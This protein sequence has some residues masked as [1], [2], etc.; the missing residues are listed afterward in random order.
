[1]NYLEMF[2]VKRQEEVV[3]VV[4]TLPTYKV[5]KTTVEQVEKSR[6]QAREY[7]KAMQYIE[8]VVECNGRIKEVKSIT[9]SKLVNWTVTF[10]DDEK[11]I[12]VVDTITGYKYGTFSLGN[13]KLCKNDRIQYILF[14]LLQIVTCPNATEGCLK[15]CYAN[16]S[17][18]N[19]NA[20]N[21][22]SRNSRIKNTVL[23][24]YENFSEIVTEIINLVYNSTGKKVFF[25]WHE[26]GDIYSK[27][28][29]EKIKEVMETNTQVDFMFYTKTV[30]TLEEINKINK[31]P[32][33]SMR[34]SLDDTSSVRVAKK[35]HSENILNTIVV[36]ANQLCEVVENFD[37]SMVCNFKH[38]QQQRDEIAQQIRQ[39]EEEL[40][41]EHR[42][43]Y[44]KKIQTEINGLQKSLINK[45]QKCHS[46][47]K[48]HNKQRNTIM[49]GTH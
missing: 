45:N 1:M 13:K 22:T 38:T 46:C 17:N 16:K 33:V 2:G 25:R 49:F 15:F 32:N 26:S 35:V 34:Y 5:E 21:S 40:E 24:M 8:S 39:K 19:V 42:K 18:N 4:G 12:H 43:T 48:C 23:S 6:K 11:Y 36:G 3:P 47:M 27:T 30:F 29:F 7:E 28:Y 9:T 20:K 41:Q 10:G 31:M 37:N 14:N 44:K